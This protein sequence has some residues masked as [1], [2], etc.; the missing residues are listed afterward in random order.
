MRFILREFHDKINNL[1]S[2]GEILLP[3]SVLNRLNSMF[4]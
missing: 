1:V 2:K 4:Q 3:N